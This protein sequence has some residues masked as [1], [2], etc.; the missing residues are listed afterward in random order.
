MLSDSW[1]KLQGIN[2][3][4]LRQVI[5]ACGKAVDEN[6]VLV[7]E[8]LFSELR[9]LISVSGDPMQRLGAYMLEGLIAR[10]SSSGS[11]IYKSLKCTEMTSSQLMSDMHMLDNICPLFKFGYMS[12]NGVIAEAIRG[13]NFVHIIDFKIGQ[14]SQWVTLIQAL[15]ARPGR[16][17]SI[18]ITGIDD[19]NSADAC[20]NG[21]DIVGMRL[22]NVAQSSG[23][24]FEFNAVLAASHEFELEHLD[25]RPGEVIAVNFAY[26]QIGRAH[27]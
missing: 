15:A 27:V 21:L 23:L 25:I 9:K 18:R 19:S 8:I 2:T 20:E 5:I 6:D 16:P 7:I 17:P 11:M 4:D 12:A 1:R 13:E 10:L 3:G 22:Y 26:Q 24:P 14:G